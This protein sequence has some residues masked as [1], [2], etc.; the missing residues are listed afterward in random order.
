MSMTHDVMCNSPWLK[1]LDV[2]MKCG[3]TPPKTLVICCIF[4]DSTT[5]LYRDFYIDCQFY[6]VDGFQILFIFNP[7][8][9][10]DE[11]ILTNIFQRG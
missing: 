11:P 4:G 1:R 3:T 8:I 10:E 5:Q 6:L 9:G 7:K 2:L